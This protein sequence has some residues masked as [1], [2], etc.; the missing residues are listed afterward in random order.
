MK[1]KQL[2]FIFV[3]W[4]LLIT[5]FV[6]LGQL[7]LNIQPTFI[8]GGLQKYYTSPLFYWRSNF[9]GIHY[10]WISLHGYG[11]AQQAFFPLYPAINGAISLIFPFPYINAAIL[12]NGLFICSIYILY[13]LAN[14]DYSK[15]ESLWVVILLICF[16]TAF[17]F[18][19]TYSESIFLFL[20]L[21]SFYSSRKQKWLLAGIIAGFAS[22]TRVVGIV[23]VPA[24]L[25]EWSIQNKH[26]K[27]N[28]NI[29][30]IFFGITGLL[31]YMFYLYNNYGDSLMFVKV[32]AHFA[33]ERSTSIILLPQ[34][35]WR[36]IKIFATV[37]KYNFFHLS[38]TLEAITGII[39]GFLCLIS[40][41]KVRLSYALFGAIAYFI[42]TLSGTFLSLPRYV[43]VCFPV[44]LMAAKWFTKARLLIKL[45][46]LIIS[47]T[48]LGLFT[49]LFSRGYW[50]S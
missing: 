8:G 24:L 31:V 18:T 4:Q 22:A 50:V 14:L 12:A 26:L 7:T 48:M 47:L 5:A 36:Y 15:R 1:A 30:F 49:A 3:L 10:L 29:I 40:L 2:F 23:L 17:F 41:I 11:Y 45:I 46:Y 16:P 20:C 6:L 19:S 27:L 37:N 9:D 34:T 21:A 33:Q 25:I 35:I 44:F 43:L 13:K 32:Q 39:F 38:L 28:K 42:P